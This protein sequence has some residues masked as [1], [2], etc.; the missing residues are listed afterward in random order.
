[1][2][3][4]LTYAGIPAVALIIGIS[5]ILTNLGVNKKI[6]PIVNLLL[7]IVAGIA[8]NGADIKQGIFIGIAVGLS[9]SGLYSGIKNTA[10]GIKQ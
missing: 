4:L 7:G 1:M 9:A 10:Q 3:E 8:L 2:T 6:I 5:S